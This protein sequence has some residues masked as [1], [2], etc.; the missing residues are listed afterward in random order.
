VCEKRLVIPGRPEAA[1]EHSWLKFERSVMYCV[2][3]TCHANYVRTEQLRVLY[4]TRVFVI[5][6][7]NPLVFTHQIAVGCCEIDEPT[8]S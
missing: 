1:T 4:L 3:G 2:Y 8:S 5:I 6:H 7:Q